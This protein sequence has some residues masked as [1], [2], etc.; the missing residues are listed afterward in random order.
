M[1]KRFWQATAVAAA[2]SSGAAAGSVELYVDSAPN[3]YGSP[4]WAGWWEN[5]KEDVVAGTFTNMRSSIAPAGEGYVDPYDMIVRSTGD[6][7]R[8]LHWIYWIPGETTSSLQGRFEVKMAFDWD[9]TSYT[10]DW[11]NGGSLVEDDPS[12]GWSQP[13]SWENHDADG[14]GTVDGVIGSFGHA[15]WASD[16]DSAPFN[17]DGNAY[18]ETDQADVDALRELVLQEQTF[19]RGLVRYREHLQGE[20]DEMALELQI[21]PLPPAAWLG[22]AGLAGVA[23]ARRRAAS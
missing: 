1:L 21:I 8:R 9:G 14:D 23:V 7:G 17:T 13:G 10:Y 11:A 12:L 6:L 16:D 2:V 19:V 20:W 22:L 4:D 18:N 5:T 3:V 15:W